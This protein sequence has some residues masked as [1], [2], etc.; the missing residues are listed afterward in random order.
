MSQQLQGTVK[1]SS[2]GMGAWALVT[3]G[4]QTYEIYKKSVPDGLLSDGQAVRVSG[5]VRDDV[6]TAAMIGPVFQVES[7]ETV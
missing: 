4:G 1:K 2:M 3:E 6:M 7:F 5:K